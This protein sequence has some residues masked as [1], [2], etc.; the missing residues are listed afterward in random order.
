MNYDYDRRYLLTAFYVTTEPLSLRKII[1]LLCSPAFS[2][3]WNMHYE[4]WFPKQIASRLKLREPAGAR[5]VINK[6]SYSNTQG[7]YASYLYGGNPG[8]LNS[9]LANNSLVWETTSNVDYGF[10]AGFLNNRIEFSFYRL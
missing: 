4:E 6:L 1:S 5:P 7:E 3:G 9:V 10:D 8:V 2:G